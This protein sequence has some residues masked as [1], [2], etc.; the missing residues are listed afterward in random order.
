MAPLRKIIREEVAKLSYLGTWEYTTVAV[1]GDGTVNASTTDGNAP[2]PSLNNLSIQADAAGSLGTPTPGNKCYVRFINGDPSRP[3]VVGNAPLC[4][5]ATVDAT[6]TVEIGP[7]VSN[8]VE[9]GGGNAPVAR[10]GDSV[11]VYF[12][13]V[14]TPVVGMVIAEP[15]TFS[16]TITFPLPAV[17][18]ITSGTP[19]VV[20]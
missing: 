5:T 4:Q 6:D 15:G 7:S 20:A 8:A 12:P 10:E 17:G 18:V 1:N 9:L 3:I 19:K 14:P 11:T 16:G 2:L 13:I